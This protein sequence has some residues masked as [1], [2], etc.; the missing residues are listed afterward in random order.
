MK[1]SG[2]IKEMWYTPYV[3]LLPAFIIYTWIVVKPIVEVFL[4]SFQKWNGIPQVAKEFVGFTNYQRI[5]SNPFFYK[6]FGNTI[7][8]VILIVFFT[9]TIG[10]I[11]AYLLSQD[12]KGRTIFQTVYFLPVLQAF[13]S[14][15]VIWRWI[16][17]PNGA[18]NSILSM[19]TGGEV[20]IGYL[21]DSQLALGSLA[22]AH[23]WSQ[24]GMSIVLFLTGLQTIDKSLYEAADI[25]GAGFWQKFRFIVIP[26]MVSTTATVVILMMTGAA[27]SFDI[28]R[29]TTDGGPN[30]ATEILATLTYK[31]GMIQSN[32]GEGSAMAMI[33]LLIILPI[34]VVYYRQQQRKEV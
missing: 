26:S 14:T 15:A 21:G 7:I 32:Y 6:A 11:V 4:L 29:A 3:M 9:V 20:S 30:G 17:Q 18:L 28:I 8:W 22:A 27:K 34:T 5:F 33:L 23:I 2:S 16:Y 31:T 13:M 12:I 1:R 25:D 19:I 24:I 10:F